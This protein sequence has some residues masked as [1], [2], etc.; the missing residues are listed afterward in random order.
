MSTEAIVMMV[1]AM[2]VIWGGLALAITSL[3]RHGA[4]EDR[5]ENLRRDL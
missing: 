4:V 5:S 3:V 1:V 2:L